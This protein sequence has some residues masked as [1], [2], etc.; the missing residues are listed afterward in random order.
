[1]PEE[2]EPHSSDTMRNE[3]DL[4]TA[5]VDE[6]IVGLNVDGV[7]I[8]WNRGAERLLGYPAEKI[9]G[10]P[11]SVF[12]PPALANTDGQLMEY[13]GRGERVEDYATQ[14]L[15]QDGRLLDVAMTIVPVRDPLGRVVARFKIG[16]DLTERKRFDQAELDQALLGA[17]LS[18]AYPAIIGRNLDGVITTWNNSAK[19]LFGYSSEEMLGNTTQVLL[20]PE[21][22][23]EERGMLERVRQGERFDWYETK[24]L[25]KDGAILDISLTLSPVR[26]RVGRIIG[27]STIAR[28]IGDRKRLEKAEREQL[29]LAAIVSSADDAIIS[30][31]LNGVV[32][33]WNK[34]AE[35]LFGYTAEEAV[36]KPITL[37]IPPDRLHEEPQILS[38]IRR[39]DRIDH[40]ETVR[41]RKDGTRIDVSLTISAI[42]DNMGRIIGASKIV[43]DISDRRRWERA[44]IAQSFL[45]ALV[46]S[47]ED[48]I[49]SKDLDGII[50]TWNPAAERL[51]G[52]T[53]E[54]IIGKPVSV[55]IPQ[56]QAAEEPKILERIRRG[57]RIQHYE[58]KRLRKDGTIIDIA[59]TVS[60]IKDGLGRI[61]GASKIA[62]DITEQKQRELREREALQQAQEAK[63]AAEEA[64][65]AKD[66]FLATVSHELRTPMTAIL[67][68]SRMMLSGQISREMHQRA[69]ETIERNARSQAQ[70]IEDLLDVSR[71]V[72]G[73]L[74]VEFRAIDLTTV[75]N[76]AIEAV[77]PAAE[78]KRISI[79]VAIGSGPVPILGDAERLQQVVWNLLSNAIRF[80]PVAGRVD[81]ELQRLE[82]SVELRV[83]DNG[84]GIKPEFL[85]HIFD[86]F[87]QADSSTTRSYGG[88]GVGLAI[89]KA[90][91]EVHGG[92]VSAASEGEGKGAVFTV[93]LPVSLLRRDSPPQSQPGL[94]WLNSALEDRHDLVGL[95]I[96]V[97]DDEPDTCEMLR[98]VFNQCG[99]IVQTARSATEA[100]NVFDEFQPDLL[101]SDIGMPDIDGYD[102]IRAI[103]KERQSRI[104][105]VALT[106]MA[107]IDDRVRALNA[108]YQMHVA[109]PVEP[110]E[111]ITIVSSLVGLVNRRGDS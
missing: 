84:V 111:L 72:S 86:R 96:L 36:G 29:F 31:D 89:V 104:P 110:L 80:T 22:A 54:E 45:G 87:T 48:A 77:R 15:R 47:A 24:R 35:R 98:F 102:L 33:S 65:R 28:D 55:L 103:R 16:K 6:A 21:Y 79:Q 10:Q 105:A 91:V 20:P 42:K 67:G 68:W 95:K 90:L 78:A 49:I 4:I 37:V 2:K 88:L 9:V 63:R 62:R 12:V 50:T 34:S 75:M 1:M 53:A 56:S 59:L 3:L 30:K 94:P 99:A 23:A 38:R 64:N 39:G 66:E 18:S 40:Y 97:V 14:W 27:V 7:V 43:R 25:S 70:L 57:E 81:V 11:G 93:K 100:L 44:E 108:G 19:D 83:K 5:S 76:A 71:I 8:S 82:S 17:I 52:Y 74:R 106:A 32:T 51:Y 107:R 69:L 26:D 92:T 109:K 41:V 58:T 46:E 101:V 85:P 61:F 13:A 60:P 73:K